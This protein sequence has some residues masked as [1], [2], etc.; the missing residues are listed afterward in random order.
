MSILDAASDTKDAIA[1]LESKSDM[2]EQLIKAK[3]PDAYVDVDIDFGISTSIDGLKFCFD[4]DFYSDK[5][6]NPTE[7]E[8]EIL[9]VLNA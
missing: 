9:E 2:L 7:A 8:Q 4:E 3:F 5:N 6:L 1:T